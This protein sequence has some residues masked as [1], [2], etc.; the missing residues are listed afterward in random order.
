MLYFAPMRKLLTNLFLIALGVLPYALVFIKPRFVEW[1]FSGAAL[2]F[3]WL[4]VIAGAYG[5]A[6]RER[7]LKRITRERLLTETEAAKYEKIREQ[8]RE[9]LRG[10]RLLHSLN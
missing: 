3:G 9:E 1:D 6:T 2:D 5:L 7:K 10:E 4:L 8:V